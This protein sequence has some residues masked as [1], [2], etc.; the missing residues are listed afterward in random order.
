M[1]K[2]S[3]LVIT[4]VTIGSLGAMDTTRPTRSALPSR[5][6]YQPSVRDILED[7]PAF[8]RAIIERKAIQTSQII[9]RVRPSKNR[10]GTQLYQSE[11]IDPQE[12][13]S[14]DLVAGKTKDG[15]VFARLEKRGINNIEVENAQ[16]IF[17]YLAKRELDRR[18]K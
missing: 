4:L 9:G 2:K 13:T 10:S 17:D 5:G 7:Y 12:Q 18:G 16:E 1:L 8:Q 3:L 11:Y 14:W 6:V 15:A